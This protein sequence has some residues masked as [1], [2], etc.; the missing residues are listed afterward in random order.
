MLSA[1]RLDFW[2]RKLMDSA[3]AAAAAAAA[4]N[5]LAGACLPLAVGAGEFGAGPAC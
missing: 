5:K 1:A 3:A 2:P 4:G